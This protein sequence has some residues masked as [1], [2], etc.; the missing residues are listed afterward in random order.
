MSESIHATV[1]PTGC[2]TEARTPKGQPITLDADPPEGHDTAAGP[3]ETVL[4]ALAGCAAADVASILR[5]KRQ[6]ASTYEIDVRGESAVEHPRVFTSITIEHQVT[7]QVEPEALRRSIELSAT[8]YCPVNAMLSTSVE[9][10]HRYR[11]TT[12]DGTQH[13]AVVARTGPSGIRVV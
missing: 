6:A 13:Q 9:V 1:D 3:K 2:R 11:L 4:A 5:K 7:G 10:E 12:A 8:R